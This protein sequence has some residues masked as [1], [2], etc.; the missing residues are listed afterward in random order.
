MSKPFPTSA[1][2]VACLLVSVWIN[3]SE[4]F[5]YF[6]VRNAYDPCHLPWCPRWPR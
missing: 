4:V 5:R 2:I 1:F 3:L 6:R